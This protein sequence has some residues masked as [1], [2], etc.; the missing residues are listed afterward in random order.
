M[1]GRG[2]FREPRGEQDWAH[3]ERVMLKLF[4][5]VAGAPFE[6]RW[7]RAGWP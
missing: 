2:P 5:Q 7:R 3:L 6:Y 1:G 4:P